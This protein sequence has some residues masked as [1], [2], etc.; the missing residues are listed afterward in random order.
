MEYFKRRVLHLIP[1][2][3]L[4]TFASFMMINLL[5]GDL[6]DAILLDQES[7]VPDAE[8]RA[9]LEKELNLD[10]PVLIRYGIWL[11]NLFM[12]DMGRS[13]VTQQP[14]TEALAQRIPVSLQMMVM[15]QF[16]A[17]IIAVPVGLFTAFR[18][19][20][21]LDRWITASAFA[22]LSVPI[23]VTATA[24]IYLFSIILPWLPSSGHVQLGKNLWL[25]LKGF[26]LPAS[27]IA[28]VEIPILM[29]VLRTDMISTLQE[30]FIALAKSKGLSNWYILFHHALRPS[31]FTLITVLGLQLGNLITG[32][33]IIETLFS[34]PGVGQLLITSVDNRDEIMVQ[35]VITFVALVYVVVN[36][37]VDLL[38]AVLDPRVRG[39]ARGGEIR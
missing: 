39:H 3:F 2:F 19:G 16:M 31:S 18:A 37:I 38:Y 22:I 14:V 7:S 34:V 35:G 8:T 11:G 32:S 29:R 13:Y 28:I 5:P 33:I 4:V 6:V 20:R 15:A 36:L 17:L 10:R 23:F 12:G 24:L 1:V 30:D 27:S 25:N 9:I 21:P 26:I